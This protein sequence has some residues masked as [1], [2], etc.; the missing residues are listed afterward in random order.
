MVTGCSTA[1][2][3]SVT[4]TNHE[5]QEITSDSHKSSSDTNSSTHFPTNTIPAVVKRVVDG[6]TIKVDIKGREET[7]RLILVDTPETKHPR[8]G[9]QPFGSEASAFTKKEL[10]NKEVH[11]EMDVQE[12]DKY[13][14]LL[15]YIWIN[16]KM[17][18]AILLEKGLARVAIFPPNT[19]YVDEYNRIQKHARSKELGIWSIENYATDKGYNSNEESKETGSILKQPTNSCKI[20]GNISS[21]GEKFTIFQMD[22][23]INKQNLNRG[24]SLK[25]KQKKPDFVNLLDKV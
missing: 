22:D 5:T 18:N 4:K 10:T 1:L 12:R 20:K 17:F 16:N 24:F 7:G 21:K 19:K 14:R 13:G 9:V 8:I 15:A 3:N 25:K 2:E 11:L 6:D 23:I